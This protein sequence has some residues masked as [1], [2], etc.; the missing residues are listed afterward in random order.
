[1]GL[2]LCQLLGLY[3]ETLRLVGLMGSC[4]EF[5]DLVLIGWRTRVIFPTTIYK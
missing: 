4:S 2:R 3:R 5:L 1:M